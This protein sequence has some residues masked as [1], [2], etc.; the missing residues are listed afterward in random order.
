MNPWEIAAD[1][2]P[3]ATE[4]SEDTQAF[5]DTLCEMMRRVEAE[6]PVLRF[7]TEAE[8]QRAFRRVIG[9]D[10]AVD[11]RPGASLDLDEELDR[12][13]D[14]CA[15]E[16]AATQQEALQVETPASG[17]VGKGDMRLRAVP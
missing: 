16:L 8:L 12:L 3:A 14:M 15:V 5:I 2:W 1:R 11:L 6:R 13:I 7:V 4:I 9:H 10:R 17:L